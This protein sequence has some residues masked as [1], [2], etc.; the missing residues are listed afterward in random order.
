[1]SE[2]MDSINNGMHI[3]D[4]IKNKVNIFT[5]QDINDYQHD[6]AIQN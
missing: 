2:L 3:I 6:S 5:D 1:M 4:N